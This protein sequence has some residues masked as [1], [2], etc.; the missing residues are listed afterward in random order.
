MDPSAITHCMENGLPILVFNMR[1]SGNIVRA[2]CGESI[3]SLIAADD[4]RPPTPATARAGETE[5][6]SS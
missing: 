3:G 4:Y 1:T 5:T 6:E 2:L